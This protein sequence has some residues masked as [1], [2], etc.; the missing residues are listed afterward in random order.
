MLHAGLGS[1]TEDTA[2][3]SAID[4]FNALC[5]TWL[6]IYSASA[7]RC[8]PCSEALFRQISSRPGEGSIG[9]QRCTSV[10][11]DGNVL[12]GTLGNFQRTRVQQSL[13]GRIAPSGSVTHAES[14]ASQVALSQPDT[15]TRHET[16]HA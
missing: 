10:G 3:N 5:P 6:A 16:S 8:R 2:A 1:L 15:C 11:V 14:Q 12:G 4:A 7:R 9:L 13:V